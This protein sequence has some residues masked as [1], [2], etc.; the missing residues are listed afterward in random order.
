MK[1]NTVDGLGHDYSTGAYSDPATGILWGGILKANNGHYNL[2][3]PGDL[4]YKEMYTLSNSPLNI[5]G[6]SPSYHNY[7]ASLFV[8][9]GI[10][11]GIKWYFR[12]VLITLGVLITYATLGLHQHNL[13]DVIMTYTITGLCFWLISAKQ[14][15]VKFET[16]LNKIFRFNP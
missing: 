15:D 13:A 2:L 12:I 5:W 1:C 3:K 9:F 8:F 10:A 14:L 7:W 4:F 11:K 16:F 6:A